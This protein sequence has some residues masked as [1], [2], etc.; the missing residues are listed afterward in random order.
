M[1]LKWNEMNKMLKKHT[2]EF[3]M[4]RRLTFVFFF[5]RFWLISKLK[6]IHFIFTIIDNFLLCADFDKSVFQNG[7][8]TL[9][10]NQMFE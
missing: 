10:K 8:K 1:A 2:H 4:E 5:F 6:I 9:R 3:C 7:Y